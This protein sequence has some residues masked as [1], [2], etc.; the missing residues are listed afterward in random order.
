MKRKQVNTVV[1]LGLISFVSI[2]FIQITWILKTLETQEKSIEIQKKEVLLNQRDFEDRTYIA[3]RNVLEKAEGGDNASIK[4]YGAVKQ[5]RPNYYVVDLAEEVQPFYIETLLK[6][7]FDNQ[8][9]NEDFIYGVYDCFSDSII[10]GP[11]Q[12]YSKSNG[13]QPQKDEKVQKTEKK[14]SWKQDGHYFTVLFPE[15][16]KK[17]ITTVAVDSS[18]W[19]YLATI[20]VVVMFFFTFAIIVI[21]RQ[22][23][24]SE[25]KNDFINNMTHE[26]KTPISTIGL[27]SELLLRGDFREDPEKLKRYAEIIFKENK[28]LEGQVER[29]LNVAKLDKHQITLKK[30]LCNIHELLEDAKDSFDLN[31][32]DAGGNITMELNATNYKIHVDPVHITNVIY[33]LIDNAVKYS[34]QTPEITIQTKND[35]NWFYISVS[36]KGIGIKR[37]DYK[38]IFDKFYRVPTGN[39]HNVKGFGLG[40]FYVKLIVEQH[41]GKVSVKSSV[42]KGSTFSIQ[43]P[44][45]EQ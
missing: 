2:L 29:V 15:L 23:R 43:L 19:W 17:H 13:Y 41:G 44:L 32:T 31:Q 16:K 18:P 25:I 20:I 8:S 36:D 1:V 22:K 39:L 4:F 37:E 38:F 30:D 35:D 42:G 26:L 34:G 14:L 12:H 5:V 21:L 7:E 10:Y 9:L 28:R 6:R 45:N 40:L 24:L 33:N 3:L 11:T 27:S